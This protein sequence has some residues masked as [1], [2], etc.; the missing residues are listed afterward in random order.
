MAS[1]E[2]Q[3][4]SRAFAILDCFSYEHPQL[5]VREI[6]RQL[7]MSAST[8][9]RILAAFNSAGIL[10]QD[11]STRL[12]RM[13]PKVLIWSAVY[14]KG[15]DVREYA[16]PALKELNRLTNETAN[17]YVLDRGARVCVACIE[18]AETV[19]VVVRI[20]ERMPLHAGSSG[21]VLLAFMPSDEIEAVL[22]KPLEKMT[23]HTITSKKD[24]LSEL[25]VIRKR[26]YAT[27]YG[28]RFNEVIGLAAPVFDASGKV[29]AAL[30]IAGPKTRFTD[31]H[32]EK[33]A[34]KVIQLAEEISFNLGYDGS[35]KSN[36]GRG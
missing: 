20:G 12:Y 26:G 32:V 1:G 25:E 19:R 5:G 10:N 15:L 13:G 9:G 29:F 35:L 11:P 8:V 18:S 7:G 23:A 36:K 16:L 33:I 24:L 31:V 3:S 34:P 27:S 6:A 17:L 2:I 4:L 30:N 28:E 14:T 21:K 22:S